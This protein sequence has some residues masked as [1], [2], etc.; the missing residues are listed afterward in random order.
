MSFELKQLQGGPGSSPGLNL[1][2][3]VGL[4]SSDVPFPQLTIRC[5]DAALAALTHQLH[6]WMSPEWVMAGPV[7]PCSEHHG[8]NLWGWIPPQLENPRKSCDV[9]SPA[10]Q[11]HHCDM[12]EV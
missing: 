6:I 12:V 4:E 5:K 3:R 8:D 1:G 2:P 7:Q 11:L 9:G 10:T